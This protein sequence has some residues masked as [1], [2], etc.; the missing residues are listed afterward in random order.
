MDA[1]SFD[2]EA[3]IINAPFSSF[4][5]DLQNQIV[6]A[7]T[8]IGTTLSAHYI[9]MIHSL[10]TRTETSTIINIDSQEDFNW[11]IIYSD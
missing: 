9:P 1:E 3:T 11:I 2:L 4:G 5:N 10:L 7:N 6:L 8:V